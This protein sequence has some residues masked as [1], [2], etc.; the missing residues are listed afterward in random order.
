LINGIT[1]L[2]RQDTGVWLN[3]RHRSFKVKVVV[4]QDKLSQFYRAGVHDEV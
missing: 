2:M 4:G 3:Y 1:L